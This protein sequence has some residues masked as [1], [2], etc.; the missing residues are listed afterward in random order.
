MRG[1]KLQFNKFMD[2]KA[3]EYIKIDIPWLAKPNCFNIR[4]GEELMVESF[5]RVVTQWA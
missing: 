5:K 3:P 2:L 1:V 4:K